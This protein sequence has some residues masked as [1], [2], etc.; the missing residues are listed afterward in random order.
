[1]GNGTLQIGSLV[2]LNGSAT[3]CGIF[4]GY[5]LQNESDT[6]EPMTVID[7][8]GSSR[9]PRQRTGEEVTLIPEQGITM[10]PDNVLK[11][12]RNSISKIYHHVVVTNKIL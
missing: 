6:G 3:K 1:M 11:E 9:L 4:Y 5:S 8:N 2:R 12:S 7:K 10:S